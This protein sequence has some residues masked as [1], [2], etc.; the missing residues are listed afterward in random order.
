MDQNQRIGDPHRKV[1]KEMATHSSVLA[2]RIPWTGK[3]G[4]LQSTGSHRVGHYWSVLAAAA[5]ERKRRRVG[6][7]LG[8]KGPRK[9]KTSVVSQLAV[10]H[11]VWFSLMKCLLPL[12]TEWVIK[13][14]KKRRRR[15]WGKL[16]LRRYTVKG[17]VTQSLFATLWTVAH[18]ASPSMGFS[19]QQYWS[20]W[21]FPS[22]GDLPNPG[23]KCQVSCTAGRLLTIWATR[24]KRATE[25]HKWKLSTIAKW[26]KVGPELETQIGLQHNTQNQPPFSHSP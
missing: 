11:L 23:I 15:L 8:K 9:E 2:W 17:L 14:K 19:R 4:R 18:K 16:Q 26:L 7:N 3:P 12:S 6:I 20:R 13:K 25:Y 22:P 24:G 1:E 5:V 10:E 21:P